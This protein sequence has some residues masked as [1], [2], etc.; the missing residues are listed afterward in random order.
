MA[1]THTVTVGSTWQ[2]VINTNEE[3]TISVY[4]GHYGEICK[5][6]G[7]P[8]SSLDGHEIDYFVPEA[9]SYRGSGEI[10]ARGR[11]SNGQMKLIIT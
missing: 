4:R 7:V 5:Y 6:T 8:P 2:L 11:T 1:D 10:Y 9:S 3:V